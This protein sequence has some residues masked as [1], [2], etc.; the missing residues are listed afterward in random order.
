MHVAAILALTTATTSGQPRLSPS[1]GNAAQPELVGRYD[2]D[3]GS[4]GSAQLQI[5]LVEDDQVHG[6]QMVRDFATGK[7]E[8]Y[9]FVARLD[10]NVL[11]FTLQLE[12]SRDIPYTFS[13]DRQAFHGGIKDVD[14]ERVYIKHETSN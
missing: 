11:T 9:P 10:G 13:W 8:Y 7:A 3:L 12:G 5:I 6:S 4:D 2:A 14:T 1:S